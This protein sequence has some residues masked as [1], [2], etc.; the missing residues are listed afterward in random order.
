MFLLKRMHNLIEMSL[1]LIN[2]N[3]LVLSFFLKITMIQLVFPPKTSR[4][5]Q[6]RKQKKERKGEI[7]E[8]AKEA[9]RIGIR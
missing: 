7:R 1:I 5:E 4:E 2:N 3:F 8:S 9:K 6:K